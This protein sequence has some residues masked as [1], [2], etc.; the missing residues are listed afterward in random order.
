MWMRLNKGGVGTEGEGEWV[1]S[2][3]LVDRGCVVVGRDVGEE[4]VLVCWGAYNVLDSWK[5]WGGS[6]EKGCRA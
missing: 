1:R 6:H 4:R 2:D 3:V 5:R